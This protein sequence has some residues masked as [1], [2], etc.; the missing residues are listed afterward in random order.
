[1]K[2]YTTQTSEPSSSRIVIS[3]WEQGLSDGFQPSRQRRLPAILATTAAGAQRSGATL[4]SF[5]PRGLT[6]C[7]ALEVARNIGPFQR[8]LDLASSPQDKC[9]FRRIDEPPKVVQTNRHRAIRGLTSLAVKSKPLQA[10]LQG[11][12]NPLAPARCLH[13]PLIAFLVSKL[14]YPDKKLPSDLTKGVEIAGDIAPSRV[15]AP[16][17]TPETRK[18]PSIRNGLRTRK[19]RIP[20]SLLWSKG[21]LLLSK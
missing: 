5:L 10:K 11:K 9:N 3:D 14:G 7:M 21:P 16:L 8:A 17:I 4:P 1:M 6:P 15:L 20:N 2:V 12:L 13:I 18:F 19:G